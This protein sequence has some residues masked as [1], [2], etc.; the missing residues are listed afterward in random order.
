MAQLYAICLFNAINVMYIQYMT[1]VILPSVQNAVCT[2]LCLIYLTKVKA[3][4][5]L[6]QVSRHEDVYCA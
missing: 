1:E 3:I 6:S 2:A 4:P 5:V